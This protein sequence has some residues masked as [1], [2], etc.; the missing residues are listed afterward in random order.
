MPP[1][2]FFD[3]LVGT[4]YEKLGADFR[5]NV[6]AGQICLTH[7]HYSQENREIWRPDGYDGTQTRAERFRIVA[8][9]EDAYRK[10]FPMTAPKL[11]TN[12]EFPVVRAKRRPVLVIRPAPPEVEIPPLPGGTRMSRPLAIVVPCFS[13]EGKAGQAKFPAPFLDRVRC[14]EYPEFVFL[15]ECGALERDSLVSV[16]RLTNVYQSHLDPL[17]WKLSDE[18]LEVIQGQLRYY[19]EGIYEGKYATA[20]EML[21]NQG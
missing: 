4:F 16:F 21:L 11:E 9:G 10:Q 12:E 8:A 3:D 1:A 13:V 17:P 7:I 6:C 5:R 2:L 18:T 15:P 19:F 14:L 20:R